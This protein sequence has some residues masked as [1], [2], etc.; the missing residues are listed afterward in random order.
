MAGP[1]ERRLVHHL[2]YGGNATLGKELGKTMARELT[3]S[4]HMPSCAHWSVVPIPLH[5]RRKRQR[6]Y[7]QS[8]QLA[9]GWS[10]LTHM[11][12]MNLLSRPKAGVSLTKMNRA[13]RLTHGKNP[14]TWLPPPALQLDTLHGMLIVDDVVTTGSTLERAHTAIRQHWQGPLGFVTLL[15]AIH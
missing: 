2:K 1:E 11:N 6:G 14:F 9:S 3:A 15:D 5:W 8:E 12:T 13:Q 4:P 10:A 7:N